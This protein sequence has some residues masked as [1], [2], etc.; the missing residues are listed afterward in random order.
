M[1]WYLDAA[2]GPNPFDPRKDSRHTVEALRTKIPEY[3]QVA[4]RAGYRLTSEFLDSHL[5]LMVDDLRQDRA[6]AMNDSEFHCKTTSSS[7]S[8]EHCRSGLRIRAD[9]DLGDSEFISGVLAKSYDLEPICAHPKK[10]RPAPRDIED[11]WRRYRAL[12][13]GEKIYR[14][15][16]ALLGGR[17]W[18]C[19]SIVHTGAERLRRKLHYNEPHKWQLNDCPVCEPH[20][21]DWR[22]TAPHD[23]PEHI[24]PGAH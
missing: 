10:E 17:R 8:V 3:C 11:D 16:D 19:G 14:H 13:I 23:F 6:E 21:I 4:R 2:E 18:G 24:H 5:P 9:F 12:G 22:S 1:C 15:A 7:I 20:S